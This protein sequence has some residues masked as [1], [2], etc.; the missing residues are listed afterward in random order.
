MGLL[1][2]RKIFRRNSLSRMEMNYFPKFFLGAIFCRRSP[3]GAPGRGVEWPILR[4]KPLRPG[5]TRRTNRRAAYNSL[6]CTGGLGRGVPS[7]GTCDTL[8]ESDADISIE[9][10]S[11]NQT[12]TSSLALATTEVMV[13]GT[14]YELGIGSDASHENDTDTGGSRGGTD[15]HCG[16]TIRSRGAAGG[17]IWDCTLKVKQQVEALSPETL[18]QLQFDL[19]KAQAFTN[20][21]WKSE[22]QVIRRQRYG[23]ARGPG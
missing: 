1:D 20:S 21:D 11:G 9:T 16:W 19:L 23:K 14:G 4:W 5:Q 7:W 6:H 12:D 17:P 2:L 3:V 18:A 8:F 13:R 10:D 15:T 22:V